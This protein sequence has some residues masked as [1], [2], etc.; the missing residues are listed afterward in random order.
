MLPIA[1]S[2]YRF[3]KN[4]IDPSD[5]EFFRKRAEHRKNK[6]EYE[7]RLECRHPRESMGRTMCS[8]KCEHFDKI[9]GFRCDIGRK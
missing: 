4:V 9:W 6:I 5:E 2:N 3:K 8:R 7:E 1:I